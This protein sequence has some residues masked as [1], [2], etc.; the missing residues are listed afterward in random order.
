[1]AVCSHL[2]PVS[3][4]AAGVSTMS[5]SAVNTMLQVPYPAGV[6]QKNHVLIEILLPSFT[7]DFT[8]HYIFFQTIHILWQKL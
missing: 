2:V 6:F 1:M 3:V 7:L 8:I 4:F 5:L